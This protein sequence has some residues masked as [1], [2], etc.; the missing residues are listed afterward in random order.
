M[1]YDKYA[2]CESFVLAE[3]VPHVTLFCE[4]LLLVGSDIGQS[5]ST[6]FTPEQRQLLKT[7]KKLFIL[8]IS[9]FSIN[10]LFSLEFFPLSC[11]TLFKWFVFGN[12]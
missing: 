11:F 7:L 10:L 5:Y 6:T 3:M 2:F 12:I 9:Q 8:F 4:H 1:F